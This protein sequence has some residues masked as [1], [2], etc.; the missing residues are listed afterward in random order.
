MSGISCPAWEKEDTAMTVVQ[1]QVISIIGGAMQNAAL[2]VEIS[3]L[4]VTVTMFLS[5][6]MKRRRKIYEREYKAW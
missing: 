1:K 6:A 2:R 5:M 4:A 3:C